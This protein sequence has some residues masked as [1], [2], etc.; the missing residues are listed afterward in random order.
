[1]L[2]KSVITCKNL[3]KFLQSLKLYTIY[4]HKTLKNKF[5]HF[6]SFISIP[7]SMPFAS[8][9]GCHFRM[10]TLT[11]DHNLQRSSIRESM[12][13]DVLIIGGGPAGLTASIRLKQKC[14]Q[15]NVDFSIC[16][17]EKGS[18]VGSHILSGNVFDPR[19]LKELYPNT[20]WIEEL[21][22]T[23]N[24]Y[25]TPVSRDDFLILTD[26][27]SYKIPTTLLP[28]QLHNE[29][30]YIISLGRLCSWLSK[31]AEELGVEIYSGFAAA[32][33]LYSNDGKSVRGVATKDMGIGKNG[34][35]K[36]TFERGVE[37]LARQTLF[38]EGARGS[39]S[40]SIISHFDLRR[41]VFSQT[42]GLGIKEVWEIPQDHHFK[43]F[44]QHTLGYP[45]QSSLNDKTFGGTFLY[46]QEPNLVLAGIV[47]GLD[48][49]NPYINPYREF[50][51]WKMHPNIR[52]NFIG[53]SCISY[54]ARVLNEGGYHSIPKLTFPGGALIGCSAGFLNTIKIKGSHTAMKS[55]II[56]AE[57]VFNSLVSSDS[58]IPM[59]QSGDIPKDYILEISSYESAIES[60]WVKDELYEVRN[61]RQ[62]FSK[63][64][65]FGGLLYAGFASH[66][67]KGKEPWTFSHYETDASKTNRAS[68]YLPIFYPP[69][70]GKLTFDL[71]TN[72]QRTGTYHEEDQGCHLKIK[73]SCSH[74]PKSISMQMYNAPETRFCPAGVYEYISDDVESN[75]KLVINSQNCIHCKCC[76]IKTPGEYIEWTVPEGGGGP[77]YLNM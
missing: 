45:F 36:L 34:E 70:D 42:Y 12:S 7:Y 24:S 29:G 4:R 15:K 14:I 60:S 48:Y 54:G 43:G 10:S 31:K 64:G 59:S 57:E 61:C 72:L 20:D 75:S 5:L 6:S 8:I 71:L 33:V 1:M 11:K 23:E 56:A 68:S 22:S 2:L 35:P 55:G 74:I 21:K 62:A 46:H 65:V 63:Y 38:A 17:I 25:A 44:V 40:E 37:L 49:S 52:K 9:S 19:A 26:S 39:C 53:G 50:Q 28:K 13:F 58:I 73:D 69:S 27:S 18:E 76:S 16:V 77:Q 51:R 67:S 32:E 41:N 47:V 30:N 3:N 66:I